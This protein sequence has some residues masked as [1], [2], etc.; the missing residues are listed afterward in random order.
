MKKKRAPANPNSPDAIRRR[1]QLAQGICG[2]RGC[3]RPRWENRTLCEQCAKRYN[4]LSKAYLKRLKRSGGKRW[5]R[6]TLHVIWVAMKYRCFNPKCRWWPNYG[7][8]GITVSPRWLGK[9]GFEHFM[10]DVGKRP[11][12]KHS[13]D[14]KN[15]DGNYEPGNVRWATPKAQANNRRN[16]TVRSVEE[17][18]GIA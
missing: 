7:G 17:E 5:A 12:R 1:K 15:N 9:D 16:N 3:T 14:R 2:T 13:L 6:H 11:S 18:M 4:E 10:A 8:R